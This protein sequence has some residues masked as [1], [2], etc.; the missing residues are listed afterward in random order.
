VKYS[1]VIHCMHNC[2]CDQLLVRTVRV[3]LSRIYQSLGDEE[4]QA[5]HERLAQ[6]LEEELELQC[7]ACNLPFGLDSDSLEALPC[8]HILHARYVLYV[9]LDIYVCSLIFNLYTRY[10][11]HV[12]MCSVQ[13]VYGTDIN[14]Q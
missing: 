11:I 14:K 10:Q 7:G 3:R 8:S 5:V 6:C 2:F 9:A 4:Q 13:D 1:D 12:A